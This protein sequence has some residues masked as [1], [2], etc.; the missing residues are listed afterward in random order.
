MLELGLYGV[1]CWNLL[2]E[3]SN[4][5]NNE[6]KCCCYSNSNIVQKARIEYIKFDIHENENI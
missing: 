6:R 1:H 3:N 4:N 5:N 2:G